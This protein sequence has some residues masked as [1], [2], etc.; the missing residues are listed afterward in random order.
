M[1]QFLLITLLICSASAFAK[2][3]PAIEARK[4]FWNTAQQ[5]KERHGCG[6]VPFYIVGKEKDIVQLLDDNGDV[7]HLQQI[8]Y[9]MCVQPIL[10][11]AKQQMQ[12]LGFKAIQVKTFPSATYPTGLIQY[13]F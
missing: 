2:K 12:Q 10:E 4:A 8:I 6:Q 11:E 1:K 3:D 7:F 13:S 9:P 5:I